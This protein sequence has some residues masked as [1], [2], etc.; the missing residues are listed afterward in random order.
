MPSGCERADR[1]KAPVLRRYAE[2]TLC[3]PSP[4]ARQRRVVARIEA[5]RLGLDIRYV[6]TNIDHG[7]GR[8]ALR[9]PLLRPRPGREPDQAAQDPARLRP[10]LLPLATANQMRLVLHTAAYWLMLDVRERHPARPHPLAS[11]EFATIR[12]RLL[13]VAARIIETASRVR[14]AFAAACPEAALFRGVARSFH[15]AGP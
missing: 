13:K 5:T 4:G 15:P 12:L 1:H 3:A 10:H 11:A 14:L 6:V 9:Q 7:H 2:T 8:M